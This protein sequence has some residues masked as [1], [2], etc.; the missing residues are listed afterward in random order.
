[1]VNKSPKSAD[2]GT[3]YDGLKNRLD[4]VENEIF[5]AKIGRNFDIEGAFGIKIADPHYVFRGLTYGQW[6]GVWLNHLF[7][8]KPDIN[9]GGGKAMVFLRGNVQYAY[10]EDPE[11][12][13]FSTLTK[14]SRLKI[15]E[16]SAVFIPVINTKFVIGTEYQGQVMK[17][18]ISMRNTARR[19]TVNGGQLGIRVMKLAEDESQKL[20]QT[21]DL[22]YFYTE[23]PLFSLSIPESSTYRAEMESPLDAGEYFSITAGVFVIISKWPTGTYR[24]SV[25]GKGVGK[26]LTKSIYDIEVRKEDPKLVDISDS[27]SISI[28]DQ[29]FDPMDFTGKWGDIKAVKETK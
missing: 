8:D 3:E 9:Y 20:I 15:S 19:D 14:E 29:Q 12:A 24:L 28:R 21:H 7:S 23:S 26:Y 5:S 10:K 27:K 2:K 22:D 25:L 13:V 4:A 11:H 17:D 16:D 1:M 6:A 18:E